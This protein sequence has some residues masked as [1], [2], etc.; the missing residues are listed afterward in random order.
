MSRDKDAPQD[1]MNRQEPEDERYRARPRPQ[2]RQRSSRDEVL[3]RLRQP[4]SARDRDSRYQETDPPITRRRQTRDF[5]EEEEQERSYRQAPPPPP[6][7]PRPSQEPRITRP[8]R[9]DAYREPRQQRPR[10][11]LDPRARDYS[12]ERYTGTRRRRE[13]DTDEDRYVE[14]EEYE[15]PV[16]RARALPPSPKRRARRGIGST[17]LVGFLG[18]IIAL[19]LIVGIGWFFLV[20]TLQVSLPGLGIGTS[21]FTAAQQTVPLNITANV[22][23]LQITNNVGNITISV[24]NSITT[25]GTLTYVK[26]TQASSSSD[27]ASQF[28]RIQVKVQPGNSAACPQAS[29]LVVSASVPTNISGSVDM[30]IVL[31]AQNP[32]PQF[33]LD[34]KTQTGN[35]AVQNFRGL[36][37]LTD[38]TGNVDVK[39]GL[40][41]AG[42]CLQVRFG[43]ITFAGTLE[44]ATPPA[45]N[46]CQG[47]PV[48]TTGSLQPWYSMKTGTGNIDVTLNAVSANIILDAIVFDQ[49][50]LTSEYPITFPPSNSPGYSGPLLPGTQPTA[51][52]LLSVDTG[53]IT[54]H[55]A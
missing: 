31:P 14:Y 3:R 19:A 42:S 6:I 20:H 28:G 17:L 48:N 21:K 29:C 11:P 39:G 23:Q 47:N 2:P 52:L 34:G 9:E 51:R 55:K 4:Y 53:N 18:A 30:S 43:N 49:G 13:I 16:R 37:T 35:I 7:S 8:M 32:T 33:V 27:A 36:L 46:P 38:D 22:T 1:D 5:R 12:D 44:T 15:T 41:D 24:D 25:G 26:R 10:Q 50:K 54:L 40:L 45:I